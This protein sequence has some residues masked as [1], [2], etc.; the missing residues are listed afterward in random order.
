[1]HLMKNLQIQSAHF[2]GYSESMLY[3]LLSLCWCAL[4]LASAW[5]SVPIQLPNYVH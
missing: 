1:M 4:K 3:L 5:L 2:D